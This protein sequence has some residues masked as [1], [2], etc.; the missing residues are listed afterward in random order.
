MYLN[1]RTKHELHAAATHSLVQRSEYEYATYMM[2]SKW[3]GSCS[4][5]RRVTPDLPP[6]L[7]SLTLNEPNRSVNPSC[8]H[9][10]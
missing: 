3:S 4:S 1:W 6:A 7:R 9:F 8:D 5:S 10:S 2:P